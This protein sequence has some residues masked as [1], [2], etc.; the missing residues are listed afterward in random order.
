MATVIGCS[1]FGT[2]LEA[3]V[4]ATHGIVK[5]SQKTPAKEIAKAEEIRKWYFDQK[6]KK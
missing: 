3:L 2:E 5:K 1:P 4:I 6:H